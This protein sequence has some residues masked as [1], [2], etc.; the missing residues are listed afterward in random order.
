V[1][2]ALCWNKLALR[3]KLISRIFNRRSANTRSWIFVTLSSV[4]AVFGAPGRGSSKTDVRPR[5]S[6]LNQFLTVAV[7]GEESQYTASKRSL[8]SLRDFPSKNKNRIT[9]R[10]CSFIWE[11]WSL[12]IHEFTLASVGS[13]AMGR[14]ASERMAP[15]EQISYITVCRM[16]SLLLILSTFFD[17]NDGAGST[18]KILSNCNCVLLKEC[19]MWW[20]VLV[21]EDSVVDYSLGKSPSLGAAG[22]RQQDTQM[23]SPPFSICLRSFIPD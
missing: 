10:H 20:L 23:D 6:S 15:V 2:G 12:V 17:D 13:Y 21:A 3:K 19:W 18:L 14:Y 4:L 9:D 8:I 22:F 11:Y 7:E 16:S 1:G 5:W